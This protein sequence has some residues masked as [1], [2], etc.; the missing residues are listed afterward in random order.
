MRGAYMNTA[1]SCEFENL[2]IVAF[3]NKCTD[4]SSCCKFS[5]MNHSSKDHFQVGVHF[6]VYL[7]IPNS[8]SSLQNDW[9]L[10][11]IGKLVPCFAYLLVY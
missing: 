2:C 1:K 7:T 11:M 8:N 9:L 10:F 6:P 3:C 5:F 4:I